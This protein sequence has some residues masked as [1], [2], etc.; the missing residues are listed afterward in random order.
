MSSTID[1]QYRNSN[2]AKV[3]VYTAAHTYHFKQLT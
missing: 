2:Y 1:F 3:A